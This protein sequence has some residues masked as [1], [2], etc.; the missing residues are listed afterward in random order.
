[1]KITSAIKM[2]LIFSLYC[3]VEA[4]LTTDDALEAFNEWHFE[5]LSD[6]CFEQWWYILWVREQQLMNGCPN[7]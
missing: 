7:V 4:E 2:I 1:M 5:A 3:K 6:F